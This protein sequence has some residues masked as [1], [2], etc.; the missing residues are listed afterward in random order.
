[1]RMAGKSRQVVEPLARYLPLLH[2]QVVAVYVYVCRVRSAWMVDW[3]LARLAG[4]RG[5]AAVNLY[6]ACI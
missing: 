6:K 1:M 3:A 4:R 2:W 5:V